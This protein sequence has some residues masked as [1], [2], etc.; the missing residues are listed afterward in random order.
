MASSRLLKLVLQALMTSCLVSYINTKQF[1]ISSFFLKIIP[2]IGKRF[3]YIGTAL[4]IKLVVLNIET[5]QN[6]E[7]T[8]SL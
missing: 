7:V 4:N 8:V 3:L 6:N 5:V 2:K 1:T